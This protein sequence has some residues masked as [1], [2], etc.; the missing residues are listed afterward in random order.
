MM[1]AL[2]R[3]SH[4]CRKALDEAPGQHRFVRNVE[5]RAQP[6]AFCFWPVAHSSPSGA[7][8]STALGGA[9]RRTSRSVN[10]SLLAVCLVAACCSSTAT[11]EAGSPAGIGERGELRFGSAWGV[12]I[13]VKPNVVVPGSTLRYRVE[14][15]GD[16]GVAYGLKSVIQ[17]EVSAKK[18]APASFTPKG[19]WPQVLVHLAGGHVGRWQAVQVPSDAEAGAY[20]IKKEIRFD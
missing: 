1:Q 13:D 19:P 12:F 8:W 4:R 7:P 5:N 18:W 6:S 14:N 9:G 17:Q 3:Y 10:M 16:T 20:R 2:S 15:R 11:A